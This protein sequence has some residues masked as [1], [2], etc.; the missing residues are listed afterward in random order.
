MMDNDTNLVRDTYMDRERQKKRSISRFALV[1][2]CFAAGIL[3]MIYHL[4]TH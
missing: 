1:M 2:T 4:L 3:G